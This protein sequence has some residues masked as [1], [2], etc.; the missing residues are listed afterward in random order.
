MERRKKPVSVGIGSSRRKIFYRRRMMVPGGIRHI[1]QWARRAWFIGFHF[2]LISCSACTFPWTNADI[3]DRISI[4]SYNVQNLFDDVH[5][6]TEYDEFVPHS[7]GWSSELFHLKLYR[8]SEVLSL[9]PDGGADI[10]LLQE[11]ENAHALDMLRQHYLKGGGYGY[12]AVSDA[13]GQAVQVAVLSRFPITGSRSHAVT[14]DGLRA[15]RPVLEIELSIGKSQLK[16]LHCH[17]K[18]KSPGAEY[19]ENLRLAA[20]GKISD[21]LELHFKQSSAVPVLVA[22][23]LNECIDEWDLHSGS[24]LTALM[25]ES[26]L[27][28]SCVEGLARP[29]YVSGGRKVPVMQ[30]GKAVLFS[31]WLENTDLVGSYAYRDRW[32]RIDHFL[33]TAGFS[34]GE[35]LDYRE[36]EVIDD[37]R[38]LSEEGFPLRWI[39]DLERGYSDHLPIL[40]Y[41]D[42]SE[43]KDAE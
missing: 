36:F 34:D 14:L 38:L 17:W 26:E 37:Q 21:L 41:C 10:L 9:F 29:L 12:W 30:N 32:E 6:G 28:S 20:A 19:T 15:G 33:M 8:L 40:M 22:G 2:L 31:P 39:P 11:V 1:R 23:D 18:S 3:P 25:P 43:R 24:Y 35:G 7:G 42:Y 16:I 4:L 5:D 13:E 27:V